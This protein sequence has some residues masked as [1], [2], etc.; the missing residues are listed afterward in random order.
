MG[1]L[2]GLGNITLLSRLPRVSAAEAQ[3][4]ARLVQ[5]RP[6]IE[7]LVRLLEDTPRERTV[8]EVA[9]RIRKGLPYRDVVAALLLAGIR[10]IQPRPIGFKF[11]AVL[12]VH[13]AHLAA[14]ASPDEDRWLPILWAVD[15]FK[16]SQAR[17]IQEGD[18]AMAAVE[19]ARVPPAH[20]A[21][22]AFREAMESWDETAADAAITGLVRCA[23]ANEIFEILCRYGIRDFRELGHKLIYICNAF[24][25]LE[26]IGW[27]HAEP[28]LRGVVH[29]VLDRVGDDNP[30]KNDLPPD[31]PF[32]RNVQTVKP[33]RSNWWEG[34]PDSKAVV[35]LLGATRTGSAIDASSQVVSLLQRQVAPASVLD[36]LH[37]AAG[38]LLMRQPGI[39]SLHAHTFTNAVHYAYH[40]VREDELR[41][42]LLLQNAA[43]LPLFRGQPGNKTVRIDALQPRPL[44]S[45]DVAGALDEIFAAVGGDTDQA[46]LKLLTWLQS[47]PD[48]T[49]FA[50]AARR[51]IF[52]KG[53][54][55]HDYK[56]SSAIL[57]DYPQV[58]PEWRAPFL[59]ASVYN[60]RGSQEADNGLVSRIRSALAQG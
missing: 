27:I 28:V 34:N 58:A 46:A 23:G 50:R 14:M 40:H 37:L 11:H 57:E 18:W 3:L 60:L 54:D 10:N 45:K 29:A 16:S 47:N 12:V 42:L 59:A 15:Q 32:R 6:E 53:R 4:P 31:R 24:R 41:R 36:A 8:E 25:T 39:L 20:K 9:I 26:L 49:A 43:F 51:L 33:I 21:R 2:A 1:A 5:F 35:D 7:P 19:E 52:L 55:A 38:E 30:S 48:P 22:D 56:F 44:D 17:D 13:A